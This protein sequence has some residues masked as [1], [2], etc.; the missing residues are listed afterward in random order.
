MSLH[1]D[2]LERELQQWQPAPLPEILAERLLAARTDALQPAA[3][4]TPQ[5]WRIRS[6]LVMLGSV[7][8]ALALA[9][10]ALFQARRSFDPGRL[11]TSGTELPLASLGS[12]SAGSSRY[13]PVD[14][15]N[16]ILSAADD[17]VVQHEDLG[18]ARRLRYE[19]VE[20]FRFRDP[21]SGATIQ[22]EVPREDI[23]LVSLDPI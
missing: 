22:I 19:A 13:L 10:G 7:A 3:S 11:M 1:P 16:M 14:W 2:D 18:P 12:A 17:G 21:Q 15:G 6:R 8:A 4:P 9:A 23:V 20:T 5:P